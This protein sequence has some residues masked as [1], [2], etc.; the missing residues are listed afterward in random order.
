MLRWIQVASSS[1]SV[2]GGYKPGIIAQADVTH[3][4]IKSTWL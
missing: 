4:F 1:Q 2:G 3:T